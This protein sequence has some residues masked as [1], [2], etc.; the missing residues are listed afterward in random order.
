M[1]EAKETPN[2]RRI[3]KSSREI[4]FATDW[5]AVGLLVFAVLCPVAA[6]AWWGKPNSFSELVT[7]MIVGVYVFAVIATF[8]IILLRG[9]NRLDLPD[10]FMYWLGGA[11]IGEVV[12]LLYLLVGKLHF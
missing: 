12:G 1:K 7:E 3:I 8:S 9:L 5:A 6:V 11:T 2:R 4:Y 10:K